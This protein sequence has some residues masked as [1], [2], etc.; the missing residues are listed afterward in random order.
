[1]SVSGNSGLWSRLLTL[2]LLSGS[3]PWL[4]FSAMERRES[5]SSVQFNNNLFKANISPFLEGGACIICTSYILK[6]KFVQDTKE[7]VMLNSLHND[8]R[9]VGVLRP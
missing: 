7:H 1:M 9:C 4:E 2:P 8:S 5:S 6:A 3:F